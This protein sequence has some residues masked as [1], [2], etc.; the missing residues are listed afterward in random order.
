M[1]K[2]KYNEKCTDEV[3][4][5]AIHKIIN[6]NMDPLTVKPFKTARSRVGKA[7]KVDP[8][9]LPIDNGANAQETT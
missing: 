7:K 9:E 6:D 4:L 1:T 8:S 3:V 5:S 2:Q